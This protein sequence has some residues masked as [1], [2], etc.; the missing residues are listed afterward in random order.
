METPAINPGA[1]EGHPSQVESG[2]RGTSPV[3]HYFAVYRAF[4]IVSYFV[5]ILLFTAALAAGWSQ[6]G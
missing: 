1:H 2:A 6:C 3:D 4:S 5:I